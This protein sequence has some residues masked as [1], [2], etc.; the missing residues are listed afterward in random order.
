[1]ANMFNVLHLISIN[2]FVMHILNT[3]QGKS[4]YTSQLKAP[5]ENNYNV[6]CFI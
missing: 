6:Q 2:N 4:D 3:I 5:L 1:M